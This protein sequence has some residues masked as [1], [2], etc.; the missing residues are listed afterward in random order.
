MI[1]TLK[2]AGQTLFAMGVGAAVSFGATL[3]LS[4]PTPAQAS[5]L[6]CYVEECIASCQDAG[7]RGGKC[8]KAACTCF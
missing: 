2:K 1:P 3:A 6:P 4:T 5:Q 7:F 8:I